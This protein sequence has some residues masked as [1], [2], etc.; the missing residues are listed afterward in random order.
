MIAARMIA[1]DV[2]RWADLRAAK[3]FFNTWL[4]LLRR[5]ER[6]FSGDVFMDLISL[7]IQIMTG[8]VRETIRAV[9]SKTEK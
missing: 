7:L 4:F 9:R 5:P 8:A 6:N 1:V 3:N 2:Y